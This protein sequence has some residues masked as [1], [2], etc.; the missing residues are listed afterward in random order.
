M[1]YSAANL[2]GRP[3]SLQTLQQISLE[4]NYNELKAA[5][6]NFADANKLG[7]GAFGAV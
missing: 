4:F 3:P 7:S 2:G 1:A 5:T 6:N